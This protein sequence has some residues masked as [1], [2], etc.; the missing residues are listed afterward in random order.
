MKFSFKK[1]QLL[2]KNFRN[3]KTNNKKITNKKTNNKK[4]TNK[5]ITNK[6]I[7]GMKFKYQPKCQYQSDGTLD[8][9]LNVVDTVSKWNRQLHTELASRVN[10]T[11][12]KSFT[13]GIGNGM[14]MENIVDILQNSQ[15]QDFTS[16]LYLNTL[17]LTKLS[18][19]TKNLGIVLKDY[20]NE[21]QKHDETSLNN[22]DC[23]ILFL[24]RY[25]NNNLGHFVVLTSYRGNL[26]IVDQQQGSMPFRI[27]D[28]I[29]AAGDASYTNVQ[30]LSDS[31]YASINTTYTISS[32]PL[33]LQTPIYRKYSNGHVEEEAIPF[34]PHPSPDA[35]KSYLHTWMNYF[36][37]SSTSSTRVFEQNTS[38]VVPPSPVV[39][40][41]APVVSPP[42]PVVSPRTR[43]RQEQRDGLIARL[44]SENR[45]MH[46]NEASAIANQRYPTPSH[47]VH[48]APVVSPRKRQ[49][50]RD[51]LI[52]R[53]MTEIRHMDINEASAIAERQYPS[54]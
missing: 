46:V 33:S 40:P 49:E 24:D 27:D 1:I 29:I 48:P 15:P 32:E 45:H 11:N 54:P 3:K 42:A 20:Y 2:L 31:T 18:P 34:Q 22:G 43:K 51:K 35:S 10:K 53:L 9:G 23:L 36:F 38:P 5:K 14:F 30:V 26:Y 19:S 16:P 13:N 44:M 8:C 12:D 39:S 41:P 17:D 50:Q 25:P 6:K 37:P 28:Y 7:G 52:T 4:I 21:I 47:V